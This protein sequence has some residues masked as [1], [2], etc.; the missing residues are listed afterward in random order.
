MSPSIGKPREGGLM[1][2]APRNSLTTSR[3]FLH[4]SHPMIGIFVTSFSM[5]IL[6]A[7]ISMFIT[8]CSKEEGRLVGSVYYPVNEQGQTYGS[9]SLAYE[10]IPEGILA[11]EAIEY[12]PDLVSVV[13]SDGTEGYVLKEDFHPST[14]TS[15]EEAIQMQNDGAFDEKEVPLY[16]SDGKTVLGTFT[17]GS[18]N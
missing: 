3:G 17:T 2:T 13:N 18:D 12:L 1:R 11:S 14:P 4:V 6:V 10:Q 5:L 15:P 9:S 7:T 8:G 16:A